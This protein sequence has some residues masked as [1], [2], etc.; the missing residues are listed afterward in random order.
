M[1]ASNV[2]CTTNAVTL[3]TVLVIKKLRN[4]DCSICKQNVKQSRNRPGVAQ[5]IPGNLGSHFSMTFGT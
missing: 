3:N 1:E 2:K 5:R 4:S